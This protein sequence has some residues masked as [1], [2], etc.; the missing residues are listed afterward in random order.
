MPSLPAPGSHL[1]PT[2]R[3][4]SVIETQVLG[5]GNGFALVMR[6]LPDRRKRA[7]GHGMP[8]NSPN[9]YEA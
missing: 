4:T 7:G 1:L 3:R 2:P 5:E 8:I 9:C 6:L